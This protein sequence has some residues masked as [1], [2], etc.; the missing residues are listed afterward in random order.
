MTGDGV[1]DIPALRAADCSIAMGTGTDAVRGAA[2]LTLLSGDFSALPAVVGEGRRVIGNVRR[3]A[4]LF[5]VKTIYSMI[6]SLLTVVLPLQYPFQ[7][8]QLTLLSSLTIGIPGFFLAM[9]ANRERVK[10]DF[11]RSVLRRA[12]PGGIGIAVSAALASAL[13][14]FGLSMADC[15]TVAVIAAGI[16]GLTELAMVCLPFTWLRALVLA[17]MS[18]ALFC[19]ALFFSPVFFLTVRT[20]PANAWVALAVVLA[21]GF[22]AMFLTPRFDKLLAKLRAKRAQ[23]KEKK[24]GAGES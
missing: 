19:A 1:N 16:I 18:G 15:S 8:V 17:G 6:L 3:M 10:G 23:S 5:L 20:M 22:A 7:P 24:A 13:S 14:V 12:A 9:E 2:Q 11:L 21:V 4:S